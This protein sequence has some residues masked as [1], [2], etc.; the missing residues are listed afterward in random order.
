M[1]A[2]SGSRKRSQKQKKRVS[3]KNAYR[4][5]DKRVE[6]TRA[7]LDFMKKDLGRK[8]HF[9]AISQQLLSTLVFRQV[10]KDEADPFKK[11]SREK[12]QKIS[13]KLSFFLRHDLPVGT[14]SK[15]DG[16]LLSSRAA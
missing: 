15:T 13:K 6:E 16:T 11:L 4:V 14:Y 5:Q 7:E 2:K 12:G 3:E 9:Q 1:E 10:P 8:A